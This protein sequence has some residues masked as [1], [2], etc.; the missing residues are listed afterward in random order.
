MDNREKD[1]LVESVKHKIRIY[2]NI[3]NKTT[4]VP[5]EELESRAYWAV[6]KV[7]RY[8]E[9]HEVVHFGGLVRRAIVAELSG[10]SKEWHKLWLKNPPLILSLDYLMFFTNHGSGT[11]YS[12]EEESAWLMV[13]DKEL[14]LVESNEVLSGLLSV[15]DKRESKVLYLKI[16]EG[17]DY[18][19]IAKSIGLKSKVSSWRIYN[20]ALIKLREHGTKEEWLSL[21]AK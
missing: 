7:L 12:S 20:S 4:S 8:A 18:Q 3:F 15:L 14:G 11:V 13:E 1:R 17:L 10:L 21:V 16:W 2:V 5:R 6:A 9:T 19:E